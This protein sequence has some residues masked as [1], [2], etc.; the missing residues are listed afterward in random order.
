VVPRE[1][2]TEESVIHDDES[3][4]AGKVFPGLASFPCGATQLEEPSLSMNYLLAGSSLIHVSC[5][6]GFW[7]CALNLGPRPLTLIGSFT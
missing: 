2:S 1:S 5:K 6:A 7:N 4:V 3:R